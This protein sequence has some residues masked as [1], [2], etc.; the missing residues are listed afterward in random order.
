MQRGAWD[1]AYAERYEEWSSR[2]LAGMR[3]GWSALGM[4]VVVVA[5]CGMPLPWVDPRAMPA[6]C[7]LI[8]GTRVAWRAEGNPVDFG[9]GPAGEPGVAGEVY[10]EAEPLIPDPEGRQRVRVFCVLVRD[11]DRLGVYTGLVPKDWEPPVEAVDLTLLPDGGCALNPGGQLRA[12]VRCPQRSRRGGRGPQH[13][14]PRM[15]DVRRTCFPRVGS[16]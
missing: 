7:E 2:M 11:P 16:R 9:L 12:S 10:V 8:E 6:E 15:A 5:G 1:E 4:L 13:W 3:A 14:R